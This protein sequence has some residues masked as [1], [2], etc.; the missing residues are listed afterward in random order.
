MCIRDSYYSVDLN[1]LPVEKPAAPG[2]HYHTGQPRTYDCLIPVSY[3]HLIPVKYLVAPEKYASG[4][5]HIVAF[6][7]ADVLLSCPRTG[8]EAQAHS[9][10]NNTL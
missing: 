2:F 1:L 4:N 3:T 6:R 8:K 9:P 5:T 7:Y 10:N